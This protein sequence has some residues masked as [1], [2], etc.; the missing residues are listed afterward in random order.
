MQLFLLSRAW[1]PAGKY[2]NTTTLLLSLTAW[3]RGKTLRGM[4]FISSK[5]VVIVFLRRWGK[6]PSSPLGYSGRIPSWYQAC[7]PINLIE[8]LISNVYRGRKITI[9]VKAVGFFLYFSSSI[10]DVSQWHEI[11]LINVMQWGKLN[12]LPGWALSFTSI[13]S[14]SW[15]L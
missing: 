14:C 9:S 10:L 8:S 6:K 11:Q 4:D 15:G 3:S 13:V 5:H 12:R 1:V 2:R 7:L